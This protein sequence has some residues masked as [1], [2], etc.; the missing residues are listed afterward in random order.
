ML[1]FVIAFKLNQRDGNVFKDFKES[2]RFYW[3]R[4]VV[5]PAYYLLSSPRGLISIE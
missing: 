5:L 3:P 2:S 4:I 1:I